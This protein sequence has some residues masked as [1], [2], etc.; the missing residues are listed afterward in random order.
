MLNKEKLKQLM[1]D[2]YIKNVKDLSRKSHVPYSTINRMIQGY[3]MHVG[4]LIELAKCLNVP[5]DSLIHKHYRI[6]GYTN[7][8]KITYNTSNLLEATLRQIEESKGFFW[9]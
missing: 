4:S 8:K 7:E 6:I 2:N 1:E 3:D 5:L 9:A